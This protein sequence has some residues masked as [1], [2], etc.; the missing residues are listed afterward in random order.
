MFK[1]FTNLRKTTADILFKESSL[2]LK[3]V[4]SAILNTIKE[5][6]NAEETTL[7]SKE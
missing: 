1:A 3:S 7:K 4:L 5:K 6:K 2:Y